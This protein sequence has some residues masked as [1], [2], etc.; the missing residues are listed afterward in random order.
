VGVKPRVRQALLHTKLLKIRKALK[1]SQNG[2]LRKLNLQE[3]YSRQHISFWEK[4][5]SEPPLFV[6]LK[7][8]RVAGVC[9][10]ILIDDS[11]KLPRTLPSTP[12]HSP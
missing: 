4:G 10:D 2:M 7:Y 3:P 8:A 6:V 11:L 12:K 5:T 1:L 9:T